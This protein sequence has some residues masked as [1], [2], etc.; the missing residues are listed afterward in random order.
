MFRPPTR[1]HGPFTATK[2][3]IYMSATLGGESDL[4]RAYGI[5][6][7]L[8]IRAQ[9]PQW[10]RRYAFVPGLYTDEA[11]AAQIVADV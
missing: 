1:T 2:Q 6:N 10:G 7:L 9:S 11:T 3:R 8:T 4:Q 5:E